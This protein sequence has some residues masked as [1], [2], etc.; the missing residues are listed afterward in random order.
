MTTRLCHSP[1]VMGRAAGF[2]HPLDRLGLLLYITGKCLSTQ[3][4]ALTHHAGTDTLGN[5]VNGLGQIHC[6]ALHR[7]SPGNTPVD[8]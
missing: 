3:P 8:N 4:P 6:N 2:H 5:L 1:P 7:L